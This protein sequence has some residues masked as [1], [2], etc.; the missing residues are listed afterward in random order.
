[1]ASG[2]LLPATD[3][4]VGV[5]YSAMGVHLNRVLASLTIQKEN[6]MIWLLI[7][8]MSGLDAPRIVNALFALVCLAGLCGLNG[9]TVLALSA[10]LYMVLVIF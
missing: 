9:R 4:T 6:A 2:V 5:P 3:I 10:L 1:M 8:L 7:N